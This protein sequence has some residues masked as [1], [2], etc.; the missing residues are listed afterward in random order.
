MEWHHKTSQSHYVLTTSTY[1]AHV[2]LSMERDSWVSQ[3]QYKGQVVRAAIFPTLLISQAWCVTQIV[4][5]QAAETA[6]DTGPDDECRLQTTPV[7]MEHAR[8]ASVSNSA[9]STVSQRRQLRMRQSMY[10]RFASE[11]GQEE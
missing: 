8:T 5:L 3:V 2:S 10:A 1:E 6:H 4:A 7:R 11:T 9:A